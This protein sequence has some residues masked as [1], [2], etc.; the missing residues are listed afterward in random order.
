MV[1]TA[2]FTAGGICTG[3]TSLVL[4]FIAYWYLHGTD[5]G[6]SYNQKRWLTLYD[7]AIAGLFFTQAVLVLEVIG[8]NDSVIGLG[9]TNTRRGRT[10]TY[11]HLFSQVSHLFDTTI[12]MYTARHD[13]LRVCRMYYIV[14][15][16]PLWGLVVDNDS[17]LSMGTTRT[18]VLVNSLMC[19]AIYLYFAVASW[20]DKSAMW[21][22]LCA[23]LQVIGYCAM[24]IYCIAILVSMATDEDRDPTT[25][26]GVWLAHAL[27]M[28]WASLS[29]LWKFRRKPPVQEDKP[30]DENP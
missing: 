29:S 30:S 8:A 27:I 13:R 11:V 1:E 12:I 26:F 18:L 24:V 10:L 20:V 2:R 6:L 4:C 3:G 25:V 15:I 14:V 21:T 28:L 19:T 23:F 9:S 5:S 22:W 16:F 17:V 7:M